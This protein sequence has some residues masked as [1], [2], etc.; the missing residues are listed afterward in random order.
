MSFFLFAASYLLW[1]L[2]H[3]SSSDYFQLSHQSCILRYR[4]FFSCLLCAMTHRCLPTILM[5]LL[6]CHFLRLLHKMCPPKQGYRR[7]IFSISYL[8]KNQPPCG[9]FFCSCYILH[10]NGVLCYS[11]FCFLYFCFTINIILCD[12]ICHI[13]YTCHWINFP[14]VDFFLQNLVLEPSHLNIVSL[15]FCLWLT[16]FYRTNKFLSWGPC[17]SYSICWHCK[18]LSQVY[19]LQLIHQKYVPSFHL[20]LFIFLLDF[21]ELW[22]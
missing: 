21:P 15:V 20:H 3:T 6:S 16:M 19:I 7:H 22:V 9:S 10:W 11:C 14:Y 12:H 8:T 13:F 1:L 2:S 4:N 5:G 17:M 18:R